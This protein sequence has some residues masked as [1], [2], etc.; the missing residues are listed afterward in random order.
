MRAWI[1]P[2]IIE[3]A[4]SMMYLPRST[5]C[6]A[7]SYKS[8]NIRGSL[9]S[10]RSGREATFYVNLSS[11]FMEFIKWNFLVRK[12]GAAKDS[13]YLHHL[14]FHYE[15]NYLLR[16]S[17]LRKV[18][19]CTTSSHWCFLCARSLIK[20][21]IENQNEIFK[22]LKLR[23]AYKQREPL[24]TKKRRTADKICTICST[25]QTHDTKPRS[26]AESTWEVIKWK[27]HSSCRPERFY[28]AFSL[29]FVIALS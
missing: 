5:L 15:R 25:L 28:Y 19:T 10:K 21:H 13:S 12:T 4:G 16:R 9:R 1:P 22:F 2:S 24:R 8:S 14:H 11:Y 18:F 27:F 17:M 23:C 6:L 20:F 26:C 3:C 29:L 7:S